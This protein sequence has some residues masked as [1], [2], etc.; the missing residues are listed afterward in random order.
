M[1]YE[2]PK[3]DLFPRTFIREI[4]NSQDIYKNRQ[5]KDKRLFPE[6]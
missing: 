1:R 2:K 5:A 6:K 3:K 4:S